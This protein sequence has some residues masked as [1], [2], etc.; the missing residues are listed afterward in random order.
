MLGPSFP[1]F[2]RPD[3]IAQ[4]PEPLLVRLTLGR[5]ARQPGVRSSIVLIEKSGDVGPA[6]M[7]RFGH[8]LQSPAKP[9]L[10]I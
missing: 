7:H 2:G 3:G 5:A 10:G 1:P 4:V 6:A 8:R 9:D